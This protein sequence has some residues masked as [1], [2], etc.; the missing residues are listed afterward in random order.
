MAREAQSRKPF[1][2]AGRG[3]LAAEKE[4]RQGQ[5]AVGPGGGGGAGHGAAG[6]GGD[7]GQVLPA[8]GEGAAGEVEAVAEFG[9]QGGFPAEV[10]RQQGG[11]ALC[12][13]AG[14]EG[15]KAVEGG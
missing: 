11:G 13:Q 5:E 4:G 12:S 1:G 9:Q 14:D 8:A 2:G 10:I 6:F 7:V 3:R 15:D